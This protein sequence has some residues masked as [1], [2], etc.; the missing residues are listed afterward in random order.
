MKAENLNPHIDTICL[1]FINS[2]VFSL[3]FPHDFKRLCIIYYYLLFCSKVLFLHSNQ[4][5]QYFE[6]NKNLKTFKNN[7]YNIIYTKNESLFKNE[8]ENEIKMINN[9][10]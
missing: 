2:Y 5:K 6:Q 10:Y 7:F 4:I 1:L 3:H 9:E 8:N